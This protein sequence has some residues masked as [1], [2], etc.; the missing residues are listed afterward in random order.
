MKNSSLVS[1]AKAAP[2]DVPNVDLKK[3]MIYN[4]LAISTTHFARN[5]PMSPLHAL[6][7]KK[8]STCSNNNS[9]GESEV[10]VFSAKRWDRSSSEALI[11]SAT[12]CHY[13][14]VVGPTGY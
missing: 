10:A 3:F 12:L 5:L 2:L 11:G 7:Y 9:G 4:F 1:R 14:Q 6:D 8:G 13:A